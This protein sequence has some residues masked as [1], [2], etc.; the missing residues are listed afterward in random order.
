MASLT[1]REIHHLWAAIALWRR[2]SPQV[3]LSLRRALAAMGHEPMSDA[4][5]AALREKLEAFR[6]PQ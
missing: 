2:Q 3:K 6:G 1:A 5:M 4:E